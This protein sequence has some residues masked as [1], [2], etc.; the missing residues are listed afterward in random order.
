MDQE[1]TEDARQRLVTALDTLTAVFSPDLWDEGLSQG[2]RVAQVFD[3][4]PDHLQGTLHVGTVY[5]LHVHVVLRGNGAPAAAVSLCVPGLTNATATAGTAL[6]ADLRVA[7]EAAAQMEM[8]LVDIVSE[9]E[10][11]E[12]SAAIAAQYQQ[13]EQPSDTTQLN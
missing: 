11:E 9:M 1:A 13:T 8:M 2:E 10:Q 12:L 7:C 3:F 6:G 5:E 4:N